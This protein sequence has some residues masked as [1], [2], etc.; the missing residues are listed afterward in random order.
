LLRDDRAAA[1]VA[2]NHSLWRVL[3]QKLSRSGAWS[4]HEGN[5]KFAQVQRH[6]HPS[7]DRIELHTGGETWCV[8]SGNALA[9]GMRLMHGDHVAGE[10]TSSQW[11]ESG[12][13]LRT[14]DL[15]DASA[16]LLM[17]VVQRCW[18]LHTSPGIDL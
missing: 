1:A 17:V 2:A 11:L 15:P 16:V 10:V 12:I 4:L 18:Y 7:R 6:W 9:R 8:Q 13:T 14:R 3:L 5:R